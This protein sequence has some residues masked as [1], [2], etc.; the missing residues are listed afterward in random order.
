MRFILCICA[1]K[2][3]NAY[4]NGLKD[5]SDLLLYAVF[6]AIILAFATDFKEAFGEK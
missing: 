4:T 5:V 3:M 2:F 6:A 1:I